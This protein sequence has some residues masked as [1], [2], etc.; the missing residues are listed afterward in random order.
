[1]LGNYVRKVTAEAPP[2]TPEQRD[3]IMAAFAGFNPG[4]GAE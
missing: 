2:L 1:M 4:G 3:A